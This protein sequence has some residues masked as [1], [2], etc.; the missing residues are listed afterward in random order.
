MIN[1]AVIYLFIFTGNALNVSSTFQQCWI[2]SLISGVF[3]F[4]KYKYNNIGA[5][6]QRSH[7][8]I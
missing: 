3:I 2:W 4:P 6:S 1:L 5:I 8:K 7:L